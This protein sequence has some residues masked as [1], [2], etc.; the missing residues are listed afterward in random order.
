MGTVMGV[1]DARG[2]VSFRAN[3]YM[4]LGLDGKTMTNDRTNPLPLVVR[5]IGVPTDFMS[6]SRPHQSIQ[7]V[8][9]ALT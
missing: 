7:T 4:T 5:D 3:G 1:V 2:L 8:P 9:L 6:E